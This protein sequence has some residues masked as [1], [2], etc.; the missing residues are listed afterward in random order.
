MQTTQTKQFE[1]S[2]LR[3]FLKGKQKGSWNGGQARRIT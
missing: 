3:T 1:L 2:K